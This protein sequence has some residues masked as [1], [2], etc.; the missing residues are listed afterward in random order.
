MPWA[1]DLQK[2]SRLVQGLAAGLALIAAVGGATWAAWPLTVP[3]PPD[4]APVAD[5]AEDATALVGVDS[6]AWRVELWQ[7]LRDPPPV[8]PPPPP[9]LPMAANLRAIAE[10]DGRPVAVLEVEPG[11]RL[12]YL[13]VGATA[14]R[15]TVERIERDRVVISHDGRESTLELPR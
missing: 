12:H 3:A 7:P 6:A 5:Q 15:Y 13:P 9:P 2:R 11:G 1:S 8:E 14:G 10:R 4:P